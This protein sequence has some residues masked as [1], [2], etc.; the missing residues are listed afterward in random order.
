MISTYK[1][2][3]KQ[4]DCPRCGAAPS[5]LIKEV[6]KDKTVSIHCL[7]CGR[8]FYPERWSPMEPLPI[9]EDFKPTVLDWPHYTKKI[10]R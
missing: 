3:P 5:H 10:S 4:Y 9:G 8:I 7:V 6:A 1:E 2:S